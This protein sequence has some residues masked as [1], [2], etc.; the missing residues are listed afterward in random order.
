MHQEVVK[1]H[2]RMSSRLDDKVPADSASP[3]DDSE[4]ALFDMAKR[5]IEPVE[6]AP[7]EG[8]PEKTDRSAVRRK[9]GST[10]LLGD[11]RKAHLLRILVL[12]E[13]FNELALPSTDPERLIEP[14]RGL[15]AVALQAFEEGP[16]GMNSDQRRCIRDLELFLQGLARRGH[17]TSRELAHAMDSLLVQCVQLDALASNSRRTTPPSAIEPG[18]IESPISQAFDGDRLHQLNR[19]R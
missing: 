18:S 2:T 8:V 11:S 16:H 6:Q 1:S 12:I 5:R 14:L 19:L 13:R 15:I 9:R 3:I 17:S 4:T 10:G 7:T